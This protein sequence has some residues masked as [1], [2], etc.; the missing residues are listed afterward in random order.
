MHKV[1]YVQELQS[2]TNLH[3]ISSLQ[4]HPVQLAGNF[5]SFEKKGSS[6][7][8]SFKKMVINFKLDFSCLSELPK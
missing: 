7:K 2:S 4:K 5:L 1:K 6:D 3:A 8:I